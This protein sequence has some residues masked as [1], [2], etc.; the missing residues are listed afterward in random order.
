MPRKKVQV[1]EHIVGY[2][3]SDYGLSDLVSVSFYKERGCDVE[4]DY[5]PNC[6]ARLDAVE[7]LLH[8]TTGQS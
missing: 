3:I 4:F 2:D 8:R 6:G 7:G 5:C 1:C